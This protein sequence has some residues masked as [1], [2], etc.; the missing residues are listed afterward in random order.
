MG[1][2]KNRNLKKKRNRL[3]DVRIGKNGLKN[4]SSDRAQPRGRWFG[5]GI[6]YD[7]FFREI[8]PES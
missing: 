2:S 6:A 3:K 4:P 1:K 5:A 7:D 8:I